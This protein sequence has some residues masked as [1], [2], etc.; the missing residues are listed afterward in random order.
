MQTEPPS[1]KNLI[2]KFLAMESAGG[3][4]LMLAAALAI[5][6]ANTVLAN[7]YDTFLH[8]KFTIGFGEEWKLSK[9]LLHWINDGLMAVFFFM[10][11]MEIKRELMEGQLSSVSRAA[12]PMIAAIGGVACPALIFYA[13]NAG[14]ALNM[15]GWA[16]PTA[17]DIAFAL[18]LLALLGSRVPV[19]LKVFLTA[20]AVIDDL[21]AVMIIA[22]FYTDKISML[23]LGISGACF[24]LLLAMN[25]RSVNK[26]AP[27]I[28]IG[29]IMWV[30]VLKS[31]VHAT[32]AGVVLG[33]LIPL[34][35]ENPNGKSMLKVA[36]HGVHNWVA[37]VI[38]PLFA[39]ANAG[40]SLK[41]ITVDSLSEPIP[42]GI[43]TGLFVGKQVGIFAACLLA[44][45][46][47]LAK[48]PE[49]ATWPQVYAVCILCGIGFTMSL[50]IGGLA[51]QGNADL[52]TQTKLG[53][54]G[55]S[56]ISG[57]VGYVMLSICLKTGKH[58]S[59]AAV[60]KSSQTSES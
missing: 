4:L 25:M 53:V 15:R 8:T 36:E 7:N 26:I 2:Q 39:F 33:F 56:L 24:L 41:G 14:D 20:V 28:V 34:K 35:V 42:M 37:F 21:I 49:G 29:L 3:I 6:C 44:Y 59:P 32:I 50:F 1:G 5:V 57:I 48:K 9:G 16:I 22:L 60:L 12:L 40:I 13:F 18:G 55:G 11:G 38:L 52:Y 30:A 10:V 27:Y 58:A 54:L 45:M 43:A 46:L 47:G 23:S 17:T 19:S 51:Y 31:G